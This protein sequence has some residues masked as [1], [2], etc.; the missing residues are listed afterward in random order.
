MNAVRDKR[1]NEVKFS[2]AQDG[3]TGEML[4]PTPTTVHPSASVLIG[5]ENEKA[6][7]ATGAISKDLKLGVSHPTKFLFQTPVGEESVM[8]DARINGTK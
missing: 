2:V 4:P 3:K 8:R 7:G 5:P 6:P 1:N